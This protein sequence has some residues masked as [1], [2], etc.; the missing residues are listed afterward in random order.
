[1]PIQQPFTRML[2][3]AGMIM[4]SALGINSPAQAEVVAKVDGIE[5]T[6]DDVRIAL[7]DVGKSLPRQMSP[8]QRQQYA[9]NYLIDLKLAA[10]KAQAENLQNSDQF[11][12]KLEYFRQKA[13]MEAYVDGLS[14]KAASPQNIRA[15]YDRAFKATKPQT[16]IKASHILVATREEAE[17]ALK[18]VQ[19]GEDFAKV[20]KEI[21]KDPGSPGGDLGW[22]TKDRMVPAFAEMAFKTE[23]G[24]I[25]EPVKSQFGWHIIKVSGRRLKEFPKFEEV[26]GQIRNFLVQRAQRKAI[27]ELRSGAKIEKLEP[28]K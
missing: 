21:S 14:E 15:A 18:R 23:P 16:E 5:I 17:T 3:L 25:S 22:F 28:K 1:M 10:R 26:N 7:Q 20:A 12:Q 13:L 4:I 24:K 19:S 2:A 9:I 27:Q 6:G 11:K 8:A